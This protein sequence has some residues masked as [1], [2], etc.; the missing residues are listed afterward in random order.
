MQEL[1]SWCVQHES[2]F[3]GRHPL[4]PSTGQA[5]YP[6]TK[7]VGAW[8][9]DTN[10]TSISVSTTEMRRFLKSVNIRPHEVIETW[11][12]R[13][14][15]KKGTQR[16]RVGRGQ[17]RPSCY[18]ITRAG[19]DQALQPYHTTLTTIDPAPE[20]PGPMGA[21]HALTMERGDTALEAFE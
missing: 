4:H 3:W 9:S 11:R 21:L 13:G 10:W 7:W 16:S 8:D 12:D 1:H 14:W 5:L 6:G 17:E 19:V 20:G 18:V 15:M 2:E